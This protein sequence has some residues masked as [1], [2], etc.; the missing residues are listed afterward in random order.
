M[1]TSSLFRG[2]LKCWEA[3]QVL[4]VDGTEKAFEVLEEAYCSLENVQDK[5]TESYRLTK[6]L[7]LYSLGETYYSNRDY[8][9]ALENLESSLQLTEELLKGHT[10]LARRYNAI[11]NCH[12][13]LKKHDKALEFYSKAYNTQEE[14]AGS[15]YHL[16][17]PMYKNQIGT[18][19]EA[20]NDYEKAV[21]C[22]RD[23][24]ALLEELKLSG[25]HDEAHFCRNLANALMFQKKYS[26][27]V[28]PADRGYK[29]RL[30]VLGNHPLTVRSIFQRA[31]IQA[32]FGEFEKA[33][34][35]FLEAWE[36]EKSLGAGNHSEVWR[37][38]ITGVEDMYD[39][40]AKRKK[41]TQYLAIFF[42]KKKQFR[43]DALK[44]CKRFWNEEKHSAHFNFTEYNKGIIDTLLYLV[45]DKKDK[46]EAE[47]DALWFYEE[48][49]RTTEET[50]QQEFDQETDNSDL[51][52]MLKERDELLDKVMKFCLNRAE[53][54]K[55]ARQK[56]IKL[57]LYKKVLVRP[58]FVGERKLA[59]DKEKLIGQV[60]QLYRDV[61]E[62]EYIPEFQESLLRTWEK[63]WKEGKGGEKLQEFGV[64]R[65]RT[66]TG[67]LQLCKELKKEEMFRRYGK[68][69]LSFYENLWEVKQANMKTAEVKKFLSNAKLVA[70]S[71]G[72]HEREKIYDKA[73]QV[74]FCLLNKNR[75]AFRPQFTLLNV[76]TLR[77]YKFQCMTYQIKRLK[78]DIQSVSRFCRE[79]PAF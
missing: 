38:I 1:C 57:V 17:M 75:Y 24:L 28:E 62:E 18:V 60:E 23:A 31:V 76:Q 61:G 58:D 22:Y 74:G 16:D 54:G 43:K 21:K 13:K 70:S 37:K 29:I 39:E 41:L 44:F 42:S 12:W 2:Q 68:E 66:I 8:R 32:N 10:D 26:E 11:G 46:D 27:A 59:Y 6:G 78:S 55:L 69:A 53:H 72:D 15:E 35:L 77:L 5:S 19:Y 51:N 64:I 30:K 3:R 34:K 50:F 73:L 47:K 33:L 65:E 49:Q 9:K 14:L 45:R 79:E 67:I 4:D 56:A 25:F 40:R 52:E 48:M 71:I 7:R 63:Q 36:M 20:Q